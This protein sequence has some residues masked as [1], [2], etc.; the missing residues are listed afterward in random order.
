MDLR[1]TSLTTALP[2]SL[3]RLLE[4]AP[5]S[6]ESLPRRMPSSGI[7][8]F[9]EGPNHLYVGRSNR[10]RSRIRRHGAENS[11]HNVAAFAFK[12]ARE[13]TG[14]T[15]ASYKTEGSRRSLIEDPEFS[16]AFQDAKAR[17]RRMAVRYVEEQDQLKQTLLEIYAAVV[18]QT[19]YND[20]DTH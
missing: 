4:M 19:S 1:F 17:V 10:L 12:M 20:F 2:G 3:Q 7:Y 14:R 16:K 6:T 8:L 15:K 5:V 18:L 9:S 13:T 11:K